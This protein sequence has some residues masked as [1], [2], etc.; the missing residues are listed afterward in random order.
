M[1]YLHTENPYIICRFTTGDTATIDIYDL[2]DNSKDVDGAG[3]SEIGTTGYFKY[4]F[5]PDITSMK[6]YMYI[7]DNGTE[8]HA[9][10]IVLGGAPNDIRNDISDIW[11]AE[12]RALTDKAG[13]GLSESGIDAILDEVIEDTTTFRE[14]LRL[15]MAVLAGKSYGGG[16][17]TLAFRDIA[18]G[19]DRIGATVDVNGNRTSI[20]LNG[21]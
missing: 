8:E 13:F 5:D 14:M 10:K 12:T 6:E 1:R 21:T 2:S 18:D 11:S 19:K 17:S 15:F 3:M 20:V 7:I 4:L 16:T 9:G